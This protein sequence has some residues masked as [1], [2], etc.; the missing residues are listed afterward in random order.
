MIIMIVVYNSSNSGGRDR[1][2]SNN[3]VSS[4]RSRSNYR[5]NERVK[6]LVQIKDSDI[7]FC[8]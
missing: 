4:D 8:I 6:K 1:K 3:Y 5:I 7:T 2:S